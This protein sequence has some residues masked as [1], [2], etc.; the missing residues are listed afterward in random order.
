MI[1]QKHSSCKAE[2]HV[3]RAVEVWRTMP[4]P[5]L[6]NTGLL[7]R[8]GR[9]SCATP[10]KFGGSCCAVCRDLVLMFGRIRR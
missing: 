5:A 9:K 3:Y 10:A 2:R 6:K 7:K 8:G 1:K 4:I